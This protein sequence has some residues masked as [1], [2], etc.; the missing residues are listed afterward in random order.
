MGEWSGDTYRGETYCVASHFY[1]S[2]GVERRMDMPLS[3]GTS[4]RSNTRREDIPDQRSRWR[5][6]ALVGT[7]VPAVTT[8]FSTSSTW[9]T[10]WPRSWRIASAMPFIPWM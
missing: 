7:A 4:A 10:A 3:R 1:D 6:S 2:D 9:L 8:M 5:S